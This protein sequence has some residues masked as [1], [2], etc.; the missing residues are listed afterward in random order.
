WWGSNLLLVTMGFQPI[1]SKLD[2]AVLGFTSLVS[3]ATGLL[4]GLIPALRCSL[5]RYNLS[6]AMRQFT[7]LRAPG[8]L[9]PLGNALIVA[10]ISLS[11]V[12]V[13]GAGL[14]SR[15]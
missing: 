14:L 10:Q 5:A 6:F 12:L 2:G 13:I 3:L 11:L 15:S 1:E 4:F 9:L 8:R 7:S